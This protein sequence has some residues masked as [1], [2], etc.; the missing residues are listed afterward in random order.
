MKKGTKYI[1]FFIGDGRFLR[2]RNDF[3]Q[4][5]GREGGGGAPEAVFSRDLNEIVEKRCP[6]HAK[7]HR[8][9]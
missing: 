1:N 2:V 3:I 8:R 5:S 6:A 7:I 9:L 4:I